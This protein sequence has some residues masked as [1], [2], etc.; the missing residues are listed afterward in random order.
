LNANRSALT[1]LLRIT[2]VSPIASD[3]ARLSNPG[4]PVVSTFCDL[5][6]GAG[7]LCVVA[8]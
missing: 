3:C 4:V 2:S 1:M 6:Y 5:L 7:S 8:M